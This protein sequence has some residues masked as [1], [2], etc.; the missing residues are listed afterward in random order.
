LWLPHFIIGMFLEKHGKPI[1]AREFLQRAAENPSM[2]G[3]PVPVAR[4][5][6]R[7]LDQAGKNPKTEPKPSSP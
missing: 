7:K 2:S 6:I 4:N 5:T 1:E 3:W